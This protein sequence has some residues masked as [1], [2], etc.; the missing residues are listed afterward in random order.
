MITIRTHRDALDFTASTA[1]GR[2][3][4][5]A[6]RLPG[7]PVR[8]TPVTLRSRRLAIP[9]PDGPPRTKKAIWSATSAP[10]CPSPGRAGHGGSHGVSLD[11]ADYAALEQDSSTSHAGGHSR[12]VS[13]HAAD[14]VAAALPASR[15]SPSMNSLR[16]AVG[17]SNGASPSSMRFV[18]R[19]VP[20]G[21]PASVRTG[22]VVGRG[23]RDRCRSVL[24]G[25][26]GRRIDTSPF[27]PRLVVPGTTWPSGEARGFL[28]PGA[29][30][31]GP[32][33]SSSGAAPAP[34]GEA[35]AGLPRP[36]DT[37]PQACTSRS[38][39][40]TARPWSERRPWEPGSPTPTSTSDSRV[41]GLRGPCRQRAVN[42]RSLRRDRL[43]GQTEQGFWP[44]KA[45]FCRP[46]SEVRGSSMDIRDIDNEHFID[47]LLRYKG[48]LN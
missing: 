48:I 7:L 15:T 24:Q 46:F 41:N 32:R 35:F 44:P 18:Q 10:W 26:P 11:T 39:R 34:R 27:R 16:H 6:C 33:S 3:R 19:S 4:P 17:R 29:P 13:R 38:K 9:G 31:T 43:G 20:A 1:G 45:N 28:L 22:G 8:P 2:R 42:R 12:S 21:Q 14:H 47:L 37:E 23:R 36:A 40:T 30:P 25:C 5:R